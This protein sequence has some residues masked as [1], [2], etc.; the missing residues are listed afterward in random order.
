MVG[1][2]A[3]LEV[4]LPSR[5][6]YDIV[7]VHTFGLNVFDTNDGLPE[8]PPGFEVL[9]T[10]NDTATFDIFMAGRVLDVDAGLTL[11]AGVGQSV[12]AWSAMAWVVTN[13]TTSDTW[14]DEFDER[15]V[16]TLDTTDAI[17]VSGADRMVQH[18]FMVGNFF[19]PS[20][21]IESVDGGYAFY[22]SL[23]VD[24]S[25]WFEG[26]FWFTKITADSEPVRA[27]TPSE[28]GSD[29]IYAISI[30]GADTASLPAIPQPNRLSLDCARNYTT[31]I[32]E[33]DYA[34]RIDRVHWGQIHWE[35]A[36]DEFGQA[37]AV[38]PDTYGGVRCCI[39]YGGLEP[40]R[41]GLLIE[42]NDAEVWR[43]PITTIERDPN[44][45]TTTIGAADVLGRLVR[46]FAVRD[47]V[48]DW[49]DTDAGIAFADLINVH[50]RSSADLWAL[51]APRVFTGSTITRRVL[52]R[53]FE[54]A[55]DLATELGKSAVD[56][57]VLNGV[58]HV[59][60]P[61]MG[62]QFVH[63]YKQTFDGPY[64]TNFDLVYGLFTEAAFSTLPRWGL[65]GM[66][67]ANFVVITGADNGELGAREYFSASS[68]QSQA[69]YGVLDYVEPN[70]L[71]MPSDQKP[72]ETAAALQAQ[73]NTYLDLHAMPPM[74]VEGGVLAQGAPIDIDNLV[75]G[76]LWGID[77][78]DHC[79]GQLI[80]MARVKRI[81]V[82]VTIREGVL[83]EKI[84]PTLYPPGFQGSESV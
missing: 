58:L 34:T 11:I 56:F 19:E 32:T 20:G 3:S 33:G 4:D 50:S 62:W 45:G 59:W 76:A 9:Y 61:G 29:R 30:I 24:F 64:N 49:K 83:D 80:T 71:Q 25:G 47:K 46:R 39:P 2:E 42:R 51:R 82:D 38:I 78:W 8:T 1:N 28:P 23:Y 63:G 26:R 22:P 70:P 66:N 48:V 69:T 72:S 74:T 73:A 75:P 68:A 7:F 5:K 27:Y 77:I 13:V 15:I 52:P 79:F 10:F 60:E 31:F 44:Q 67:Q 54:A 57:F 55:S 37:S 17:V 43:G 81:S 12:G 36:L 21:S 84:S 16:F 6:F 35:R 53:K 18:Y 14:Y 65:N 40:W 41:F